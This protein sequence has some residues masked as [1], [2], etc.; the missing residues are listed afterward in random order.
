MTPDID[1][2]IALCENTTDPSEDWYTART[3]MEDG[4]TES[5]AAFIAACDPQTILALC[6]ENKRLTDEVERL[7]GEART[8]R[9]T[10]TAMCYYRMMER[11]VGDPRVSVGATCTNEIPMNMSATG[12][13]A[14]PASCGSSPAPIAGSSADEGARDETALTFAN[15]IGSFRIWQERHYLV[16]DSG[17]VYA[18]VL[19]SDYGGYVAGGRKFD[20]LE[21]A[22]SEAT[23]L[24]ACG[25][26]GATDPH[27]HT[28]QHSGAAI[29]LVEYSTSAAADKAEAIIAAARSA[30]DPIEQM[31]KVVDV[32]REHGS[33]ISRKWVQS[34]AEAWQKERD[35]NAAADGAVTVSDSVVMAA[36]IAAYSACDMGPF[37]SMAVDPASDLRFVRAALEA[38]L[39]A[40][41]GGERTA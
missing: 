10:G 19:R 7:R 41:L 9:M 37:P 34:W 36:C 23:K 32:A 25:Q 8:C 40:A 11:I 27:M 12:V 4:F 21:E 20:T 1:R 26:C 18:T 13:T 38:A 16:G 5:D 14:Q 29:R 24:P 31:L 39:A 28:V 30:D 35:A 3:L 6:A 33:M 17:H 15:A 2:L 22:K